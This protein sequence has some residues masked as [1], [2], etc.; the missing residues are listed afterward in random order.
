MDSIWLQTT[1]SA[2]YPAL[3][4]DLETDIAVIGGG[5][6]GILTAYFLKKS[7]CNV[8]LLE[9]GRIGEGVTAYT[10]GKITSQHGL[11]YSP[12]MKK[13][14]EKSA[15]LYAAAQQKAIKAFQVIIEQEQISCDFVRLPAFLYDTVENPLLEKEVEAAKRLGLPAS[16]SKDVGLPF[17]IWGAVCFE[18]QAQFHPLKFLHQLAE[19]LTIFENTSVEKIKDRRLLAISPNGTFTVKANDIIVATHY[20]QKNIPGFY[21]LRMHQELSYLSAWNKVKPLPGM[22]LSAQKNGLTLRSYGDKLLL[23]GLGHRT[24]QWAKKDAYE[25]L[26]TFAGQYFPDAKALCRWSTEDC[27][28]LDEIPYI[29]RYS[30]VL[31][32]LYLASGFKKWGMTG[33]MT[34]AM[35]LTDLLLDTPNELSRIFRPSRFHPLVTTAPFLKQTGI[36][37]DSLILRKFTLPPNLQKAKEK[38]YG[39]TCPHLG[40]TMSWNGTDRTWECP[41]HGSRCSEDGKVLNNPARKAPQEIP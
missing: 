34:A 2:H 40:C 32:N 18:Q 20:P 4:E 8:V 24:G 29:G 31:P 19:K 25:Q 37:T 15:R 33:S 10:T 14:G 17:P 27:F 23:G 16:F 28:T 26:S 6:A 39:P 22:Y 12:M 30:S 35:L 5:M 21:F 1:D 38:G 36:T 7:G 3:S 11:W 41:C 9:A 13:F